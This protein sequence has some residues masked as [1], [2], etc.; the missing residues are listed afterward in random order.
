MDIGETYEQM[1]QVK[2]IYNR[3]FYANLVSVA[4]NI[5]FNSPIFYG[6]SKRNRS[7]GSAQAFIC[8]LALGNP[9]FR[10][11]LKQF[12]VGGGKNF[13]YVQS[14]YDRIYSDRLVTY[15]KKR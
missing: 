3:Q 14:H 11:Y 2:S 6:M 5:N 1:P 9:Q 13:F 4:N 12:M 7:L 15:K 8:E 10:E